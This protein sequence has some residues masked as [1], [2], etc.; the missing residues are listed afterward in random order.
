V[1]NRQFCLYNEETPNTFCIKIVHM[2]APN[3]YHLD[4]VSDI[5]TPTPVIFSL[6]YD[7][8]L[9]YGVYSCSCLVKRWKKASPEYHG[10]RNEIQ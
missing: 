5:N 6:C 3:F 10:D 2:C 8:I 1:H 4:P 7:I 9:I